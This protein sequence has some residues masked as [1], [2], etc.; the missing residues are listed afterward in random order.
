[1]SFCIGCAKS[2]HYTQKF[3]CGCAKDY[4]HCIDFGTKDLLN[5]RRGIF[6]RAVE[7]LV[8][9]SPTAKIMDIYFYPIG[10]VP[11]LIG[12]GSIDSS[13]IDWERLRRDVFNTNSLSDVMDARILL[14]SIKGLPVPDEPSEPKEY[15]KHW[16]FL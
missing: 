15:K 5:K 13:S 11:K 1:M 12:C 4:E 3:H 16:E 6:D 2:L 10:I 8:Y 9:N 14:C 7:V